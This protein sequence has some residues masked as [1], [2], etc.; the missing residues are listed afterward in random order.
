VRQGGTSQETFLCLDLG[1]VPIA[2]GGA[3]T[4]L[5]RSLS[6]KEDEKEKRWVNKCQESIKKCV[7]LSCTF[8]QVWVY[9]SY[10]LKVPYNSLF[11]C[12]SAE[13]GTPLPISKNR[14]IEAP[15]PGT[16]LPPCPK[17]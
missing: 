5:I 17:S 16:Q 12:F 2:N 15:A 3:P 4:N 9:Q 1:L 10:R 6:M 8:F 11:G 14:K 13:F 7:V